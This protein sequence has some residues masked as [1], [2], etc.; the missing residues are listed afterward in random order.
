MGE[1]S[2]MFVKVAMNEMAWLSSFGPRTPD[3]ALVH[4]TSALTGATSPMR[5]IRRDF[6]N[7]SA[8]PDGFAVDHGAH[9]PQHDAMQ[10]MMRMQG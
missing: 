6:A 9:E 3:G 10:Q 8:D 5:G 4:G 2:A 1:V 7:R